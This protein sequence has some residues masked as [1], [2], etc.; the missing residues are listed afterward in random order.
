MT[1]MNFKAEVSWSKEKQR[2][3]THTSQ[4]LDEQGEQHQAHVRIP[5]LLCLIHMLQGTRAISEGS[6][7]AASPLRKT[8][9][10]TT[11]ERCHLLGG[12]KVEDSF[13]HVC[14]HVVRAMF[15]LHLVLWAKSCVNMEHLSSTL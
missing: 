14:G 3:W 2:I 10:K 5:W 8:F 7:G 9:L 1:L 4:G 6:L 13:Q 11:F 15:T 12:E